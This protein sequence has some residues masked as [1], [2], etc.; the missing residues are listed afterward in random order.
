LSCLVLVYPCLVPRLSRRGI[1]VQLAWVKVKVRV[2]V[3]FL[4][5]VRYNHIVSVRQVHAEVPTA[6]L[7]PNPILFLTLP[8]PNLNH[9]TENSILRFRDNYRR[10]RVKVRLMVKVEVRIR[11]KSR[12]VIG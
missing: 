3:K 8:N 2:G 1:T 4:V 6:H 11:V 9:N 10:N 5:M 7:N 12:D